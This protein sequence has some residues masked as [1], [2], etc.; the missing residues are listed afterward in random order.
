MS[1]NSQ[2][3]QSMQPMQPMQPMGVP[4]TTV[5]IVQQ[6]C[7]IWDLLAQYKWIIIAL[8]VAFVYMRYFNKK[9]KEEEKKA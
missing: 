3:M 7:S 1:F 4:T 9:P 8:I 2:P 5:A 6:S